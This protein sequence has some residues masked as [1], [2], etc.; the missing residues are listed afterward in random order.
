MSFCCFPKLSCVKSHNK[1][2]S[3][4]GSPPNATLGLGSN[5]SMCKPSHMIIQDSNH[6]SLMASKSNHNLS[7]NSK[8]SRISHKSMIAIKYFDKFEPQKL[9]TT[10]KGDESIASLSISKIS[11]VFVSDNSCI[12]FFSEIKIEERKL[13]NQYKLKPLER[14]RNPCKGIRFNRK[15]PAPMFI[16]KQNFEDSPAMIENK[17]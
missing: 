10:L 13:Q 14:D 17:K 16:K 15:E 3:A 7:K 12:D 2:R 9:K 1:V 8:A 4:A 6:E 11:D 5:T